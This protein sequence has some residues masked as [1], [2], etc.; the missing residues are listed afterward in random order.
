MRSFRVAYDKTLGITGWVNSKPVSQDS[1]ALQLL[2]G[3]SNF[4]KTY[5]AYDFYLYYYDS[6]TGEFVQQGLVIPDFQNV[7]LY[8][9]V[10]TLPWAQ[11]SDNSS[12]IF[13][14]GKIKDRATGQ[15]ITF[16][17]GNDFFIFEQVGSGGRSV[18]YP[19]D[20]DNIHSSIPAVEL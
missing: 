14:L 12:P 10:I 8:P 3:L 2:N 15:F 20:D 4:N 6:N 7:K 13:Y 16:N 5:P 19:I 11:P 18:I 9:V 17:S 1:I